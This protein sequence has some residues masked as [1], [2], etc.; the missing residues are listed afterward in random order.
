[1]SQIL[2]SLT[3]KWDIRHKSISTAGD[4]DEHII[5]SQRG[6]RHE[7]C[8]LQAVNRTRCQCPR[9]DVGGHGEVKGDS[10]EDS[11]MALCLS[12]FET[13]S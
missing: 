4:K 13:Q 5:G 2:Y 3:S 10:V 8:K 6:A 11:L 1:M 7:S 12:R 9:C